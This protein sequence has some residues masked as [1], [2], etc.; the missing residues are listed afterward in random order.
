MQVVC[1]ENSHQ[2]GTWRELPEWLKL[3]GEFSGSGKN[4]DSILLKCSQNFPC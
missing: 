3:E 2:D 4:A 1:R